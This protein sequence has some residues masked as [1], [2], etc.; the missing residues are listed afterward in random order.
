MVS[1]VIFLPTVKLAVDKSIS[2][3]FLFPNSAYRPLFSFRF[4]LGTPKLNVGDT[5]SPVG[6][7]P[8][9]TPAIL[10]TAA[11]VIERPSVATLVT[12]LNLS[13]VSPVN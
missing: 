9:H 1:P 11:R 8:L 3:T 13:V 12:L 7:A 2:D 6:N 5:D 4:I 10:L